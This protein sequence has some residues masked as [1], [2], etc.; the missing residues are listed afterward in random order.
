[1]EDWLTVN[2]NHIGIIYAHNNLQDEEVIAFHDAA[3]HA[4]GLWRQVQV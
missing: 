3:D 1:M 2:G 4:D